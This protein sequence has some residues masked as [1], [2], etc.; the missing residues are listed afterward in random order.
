MPG[1][2]VRVLIVEDLGGLRR[3]LGQITARFQ[4]GSE[5]REDGRRK[6][7]LVREK[8]RQT[9]EVTVYIFHL[10]KTPSGR[11]ALARMTKERELRKKKSVA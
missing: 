7:T 5:E 3:L 1:K 9:R 8:V 11:Q 6:G 10:L 4:N 2:P